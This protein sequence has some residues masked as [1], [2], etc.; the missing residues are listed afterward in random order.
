MDISKT[1]SAAANKGISADIITQRQN[2]RK[3]LKAEQELEN[4][5]NNPNNLSN[6]LAQSKK[7][8]ADYNLQLGSSQSAPTQAYKRDAVQ[9]QSA[10]VNSAAKEGE[11]NAQEVALKNSMKT[12]NPARAAFEQTIQNSPNR[13]ELKALAQKSDEI[14]QKAAKTQADS[15]NPQT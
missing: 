3:A 1:N 14:I 13:D 8:T 15:I 2:A 5:L 10:I 7:A 12:T 6:Q 11:Q 9:N 4:S